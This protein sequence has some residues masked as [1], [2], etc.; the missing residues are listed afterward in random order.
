[1]LDD[2]KFS[3]VVSLLCFCTFIIAQTQRF[4]K[5]YFGKIII[6]FFVQ[7]AY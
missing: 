6:Y 1:V 7:I 5:H 4:V 3:H 2:F